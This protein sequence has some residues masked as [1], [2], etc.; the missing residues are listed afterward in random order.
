MPQTNIYAYEINLE[1]DQA[2]AV[3]IIHM[4]GKQKRV[5]ELGMASGH[6]SRVLKEVCGCAVVGVEMNPRWAEEGRPYCE[7]VIVG[8]LEQLDLNEAIGN[9]RFDVLLAADVLEHLRDP[10]SILERLRAYLKPDGYAVISVPNAGFHGLVAELRGG[11]FSYRG[12]GL[13]DETHLRWFTRHELELLVLS[14]GFVPDAWDQALLGAEHSEFA[15]SWNILPESAQRLLREARDGEAYQLIVRASLPDKENWDRYLRAWEEKEDGGGRLRNDIAQLRET[16]CELRERLCE[17]DRAIHG[18]DQKILEY[19][20]REG[21]LEQERKELESYIYRQSVNLNAQL[22]RSLGLQKKL[23]DEEKELSRARSASVSLRDELERLNHA[24]AAASAHHAEMEHRFQLLLASKSWKVT[25]PLRALIRLLHGSSSEARGE[26]ASETA[27]LPV[28]SPAMPGHAEEAGMPETV[29]VCDELRACQDCFRPCDDLTDEVRAAMRAQIDAMRYQPQIGVR[30]SLLGLDD[31]A[32]RRGFDAVR[33]QLYPRWELCVVDGEWASETQIAAIREAMSH[34]IR[35]RMVLKRVGMLEEEI[36][37]S[38]LIEGDYLYV[39]DPRQLPPEL[40]FYRL[41]FFLNK[42]NPGLALRTDGGAIGG[43]YTHWLRLFSEM[44][45]GRVRALRA[46]SAGFLHKPRISII[47][48]VFNTPEIWLHKAIDSVIGQYYENW[49]LCIADDCSSETSVRRVLDAYR[50]GDHR[51]KVVFHDS[52]QHISAAS[53]SALKLATGEFVAFLDHDDELTPDALLW[54]VNEINLFPDAALI[55]SDEDKLTTSGEREDPYFKPDWNPDLL[56][57][58]N[59]VCHLAVY[60]SDWVRQLGGLR[61]G[62]EGAQDYD[63]VLRFVE[64]AHAQQIR[65]IPRVLYHWRTIPGSTAL[66]EVADAKPYAVQA[67]IRSIGEHLERSGVAATVTESTES[68]GSYRVQYKLP[69]IRPLVSLI[70]LTRNGLA[71]LR[72]CM[73]SILDKT[74]YSPYEIIVVDNG[75]DEQETLEYLA[76]LQARKVARVI[77]DDRPF[78]FPALNNLAVREARGTIIGLLNND[79]EVITPDWLGEMVSHALRPEI[80]AVGARL[81]YPDDT[82]QHGGVIL[83]GG[84]AGHANKHLPKG[85]QGYCRRG[86]LIQNYSAVTAACMVLRKEVYV[87]AGGMDEGLA[88]AFND[89][90]FCLKIRSLGYRNLWTPYAELYHHESATRGYEDTPEKQARFRQEILAMKKRWGN[91]LENDP[92]YN[93]NLSLSREDFS[94]SFPPRLLG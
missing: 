52:N 13:L 62:F 88:V 6:M 49:E 10:W 53:N 50:D 84:V 9:D 89:V 48:P 21:K 22:S 34:D 43:T 54:V 82:L 68:P 66:S 87:S 25:A 32:F 35:I 7:R 59:F 23:D 41:A 78:N 92:A 4:V 5:L 60:R 24:L 64:K 29:P 56:L 39:L 90:D 20:E 70:V 26:A 17:K 80:G 86:V 65:H 71:L 14:C 83:V 69:E 58:Q 12:K 1:N 11:K 38:E 42:Y 8:D 30:F 77:R 15:E 16:L 85:H 18:L 57:S 51:I 81:W 33:H 91:L 61:T 37:A 3:K 27:A 2:A 28:S 40:A 44:N 45:A 93:P 75:S 67:A 63:L 94:L 36:T 46:A 31:D 47:L 74:S 72:Q 73:D 76:D 55:Y 19:R 79:I